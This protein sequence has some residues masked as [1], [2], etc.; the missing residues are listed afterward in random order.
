MS[1]IRKRLAV[2]VF[3]AGFASAG[4]HAQSLAKIEEFYF[5]VDSAASPLRVVSQEGDEA[6]EP[7]MKL[8]E[9]GRKAVEAT[10]QLARIAIAQGRVDLGTSLHQEALASAPAGSIQGRAV[11]WNY[12][13]DLFHLGNVEAALAQW[14]EVH[15]TTRG[16]P[17]WVPVTYALALW[18]QGQHDDAVR[19][20][21]AAVRTDPQLW[22]SPDNLAA[23]L[24]EWREQ[25]RA[26][27][28]QVH[29]R[30]SAAPPAWP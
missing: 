27:I 5:D 1:V 22:S 18:T 14:A 24:P 11:R 10:S 4:A 7:L 12:A 8:R 15:A 21:A 17:G 25:D 3:L 23:L 2:W 9:R 20:Y 6:I 29:A 26:V 13:W 30:W 28:A 19:W 16:N